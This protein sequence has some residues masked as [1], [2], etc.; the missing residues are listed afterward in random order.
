MNLR[1]P[2]I[3]RADAFSLRDMGMEKKFSTFN[4]HSDP[5]LEECPL[6]R[7][8]HVTR[9]PLPVEYWSIPSPFPEGDPL[10]RLLRMNE[11]RDFAC[12]KKPSG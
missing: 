4:V 1:L 9:S 10:Y 3:L 11:R 8:R 5:F 12:P 6:P 2:L 7:S